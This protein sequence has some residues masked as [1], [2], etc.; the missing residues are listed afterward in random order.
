MGR[1]NYRYFLALLLSLGI[2][3]IY[4][5]YLCW[6]ILSPHLVTDPGNAFFSRAHFNEILRVTVI[7]VNIGGLSIAGVGMLAAATAALPLGLMAYHCYL[8]WA[9][10]TT[11]E[12]QKW[13]DLRE[14]MADGFAFKGSREALNTHNKLRRYGDRSEA[15]ANGNSNPALHSGE[16]MEEVYVAWPISSDQIVTRT[17]DGRPPYGQ[18]ALWTRVWN[19]SDVVNLYDLGGWDNFMEVLKGR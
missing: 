19:L 2:V 13:A 12:S 4:G 15:Y 9:G 7:A 3:E 11:N 18:E 8:I 1:A 16:G 14:D 5:A 6:W 17:T 10:M